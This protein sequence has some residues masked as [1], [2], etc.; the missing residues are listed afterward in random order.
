MREIRTHAGSAQRRGAW[1]SET[2]S[3]RKTLAIA[4]LA[5]LLFLFLD[6]A[7]A[8]TSDQ[9]LSELSRMSMV[10]L[11][12]A[13]V[14][15]TSKRLEAIFEAPGVVSVITRDEIRLFG[16]RNLRQVLQYLP[17]IWSTGSYLRPDMVTI[18][19]NLQT[20][21]KNHVL[22]L[23]NGRPIRESISGG[24]HEPL[25]LGFPVEAIDRIELVRGPGSVLY[26]S[27][28]YSGVINIVTSVED[29]PSLSAIAEVGSF[30]Y[31]SATLAGGDS[32]G[33]LRFG[34]TL[35]FMNEDGWEFSAVDEAM[36]QDSMD[37]AKKSIAA[38]LRAE[39][40]GWS[41]D[42]FTTHLVRNAMGGLPLWALPGNE[43][44]YD[45]AFV[46][47]GYRHPFGESWSVTANVAFN[48]HDSQAQEGEVRGISRDWLWEL[49]ASGEPFDGFNIVVGAVAEYLS[50]PDSRRSPLPKYDESPFRFYVQADYWVTSWAKLIAGLQLNKREGH[51]VNLSPRAGVIFLFDDH[52]GAKLLYGTAF[53]SPAAIE[54]KPAGARAL[55]WA[56]WSPGCCAAKATNSKATP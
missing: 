21:I 28:A 53:R 43:T 47:L 56:F 4:A 34:A 9:Q 2:G 27:N 25:Y 48:Y 20:H 41:L 24:S 6:V 14:K 39:L 22:T 26:G 32:I 19:G 8:E 38:T 1:H 29:A 5:T 45:R 37:M 49:T 13:K 31:V 16:A 42:L 3:T 50:G 15:V 18:R 36:S 30:D 54:T 44:E 55:R 11:L 23:L 12:S 7:A 46:N 10:E 51:E 33:P 35:Q 17:G 52:R 40:N